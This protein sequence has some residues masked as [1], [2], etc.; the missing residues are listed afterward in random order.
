MSVPTPRKRAWIGAILSPI[1]GVL[2][3]AGCDRDEITTYR[4]PKPAPAKATRAPALP[5]A[6]GD[7]KIAFDVPASWRR[8]SSQQ[9][10]RYAT[11][12][13]GP[14]AAPVE[15]SVTV[16]PGDAG[17]LIP[18]VN[19]WR[20]QI[21]LP[22]V[23]DFKELTDALAI[24]G[25]A[26]AGVLLDMTGKSPEGDPQ[27]VIA[28][29]LR[30]DD[31]QT[32]FVKASGKPESL[33][34]IRDEVAVFSRSFRPASDAV[35]SPV[36]DTAPASVPNGV[37][38]SA[39]GLSWTSPQ[40]WRASETP[41]KMLLAEFSADTAT[42]PVRITVSQLPGDGGGALSNIN[43]WRGQV[44]LP[45]LTAPE[46]QPVLPL[47]VGATSNSPGFPGAIFDM[48]APAPTADGTPRMVIAMI[49]GNERAYFLKLTGDSPAVE[50]EKSNFERFVQ[51]LKPPTKP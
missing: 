35:T 41:S 8:S 51:S 38:G 19:R 32:W 48:A 22:P 12:L 27:R 40:N 45:P 46:Q 34:A 49:A 36:T 29:A 7:T 30:V 24:Q 21:G 14:Q 13:A 6:V 15:V 2:F 26:V 18:N 47:M 50:K 16:F 43:R 5:S 39:A 25:E 17:G 1:V 11:F 33:D 10:M 4:A 9:S 42:G 3:L 31:K 37:P 28:T 23:T 44:G 20:G